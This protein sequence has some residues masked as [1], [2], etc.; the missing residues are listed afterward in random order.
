[1]I[2]DRYAYSGVVYS[3]S[4]GL[5]LEWCKHSDIG[6]PEPDIVLYMDISE[7]ICAQR[8]KFGEEIFERVE[9]QKKVKSNYMKLKED[10]WCV[11]N[12]N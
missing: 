10:R 11:I 6:L 8:N 9:F 7:E 3:A 5:D 1:M 2:L 4:K 12:G